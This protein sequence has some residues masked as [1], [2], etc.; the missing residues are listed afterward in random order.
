MAHLVVSSPRHLVLLHYCR[1]SL[2]V[3]NIL[4]I[5]LNA[6][7]NKQFNILIL[8]SIISLSL[9]IFVLVSQVVQNL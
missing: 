3:F 9:L 8:P 4:L 1:L 5:F 7:V 2:G 6:R